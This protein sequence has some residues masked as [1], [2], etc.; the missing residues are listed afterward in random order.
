MSLRM[1]DGKFI[2]DGNIF[3]F[4]A[5][6]S[7]KTVEIYETSYPIGGVITEFLNYD[8]TEYFLVSNELEKCYE[9]DDEIGFLN[10]FEILNRLAKKMP[11]YKQRLKNTVI[12][13]PSVNIKSEFPQIDEKAVIDY[14]KPIMKKAME[15]YLNLRDDLLSIKKVYVHLLEE[16][17]KEMQAVTASQKYEKAIQIPLLAEYLQ[18]D[19]L[20]A[21][22][23]DNSPKSHTKFLIRKSLVTGELEVFERRIFNR[24]LDFIYIEFCKALMQMNMPKKCKNCG[25]Y[26]L[27]ENGFK[28]E[29]CTRPLKDN[30]KK[31]CRD[32]GA[33]QNFK[34][35]VS[36]S[37]EWKIHQR[38]YKKYYARLKKGQM[39]Q[40]EFNEWARNA[41]RLRSEALEGTIDTEDYEKLLN[42]I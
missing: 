3:A 31:T 39:T 2:D 27:L 6:F 34:T 33:A 1:S 9:N 42:N 25:M 18:G 17:E 40:A 12:L 21:P 14:N 15:K 22:Y 11:M 35:K 41:E 7:D 36:Q 29:Y 24:L 28:N 16:M 4:D 26:F 5:Y 30:P 32:V 23:R 13:E 38:A 19:G 8:E 20:E 37:P 10:N